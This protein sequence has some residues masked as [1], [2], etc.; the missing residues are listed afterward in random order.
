MS[1]H[2]V[3]PLRFQV[4]VISLVGVVAFLA[5][6]GFAALNEKL[7]GE[8]RATMDRTRAAN[9]LVTR[10]GL[11]FETAR[12]L[13]QR[14]IS[15]QRSALA[16]AEGKAMGQALTL[17][18]AA[19]QAGGDARLGKEIAELRRLVDVYR[20]DFATVQESLALLGTT[21]TP[22]LQAALD[23]AAM[24]LEE[25]L[26]VLALMSQT[27]S[28]AVVRLQL[29]VARQRGHERDFRRSGDTVHSA[30]MVAPAAAFDEALEEAGL[31]AAE[32]GALEAA[33]AAYRR[34]FRGYSDVRV[35]MLNQIEQQR[36]QAARLG[37][38]MEELLTHN[39]ARVAAQAVETE[40]R[41]AWLEQANL[42]G[43]VVALLAMAGTGIAIGRLIARRVARMVDAVEALA[44][45]RR[46]IA[47]PEA[48]LVRDEMTELAEATRV[49]RE[50]LI[51][52][53]R[54]A[55]A[56]A[57]AQVQRQARQDAM[58]HHTARFA[59]SIAGILARLGAASRGI[60][61]AARQMHTQAARSGEAVGVT[62]ADAQRVGGDLAA[63]AAA[64]E[65]LGASVNEITRQVGHA[66]AQIGAATASVGATE[67]E[68]GGL[69]SRA[70]EIE[71][72]LGS[73]AEIAA[74]TSLL[75][76]NA[77][78]EAARAGE[79]GRGFAVVAGEVKALAERSSRSAREIGQRID[80]VRHASS[81]AEAEMAR[82]V[83][84]IRGVEGVAAMIAAAVEEQE[85]ATR[86]IAST[87]QLVNRANAAT[88]ATLTEVA[89]IAQQ[90]GL[91]SQVVLGTAE[92]LAAVAETLDAEVGQFLA[93]MRG[94]EA[95]APV[96]AEQRMAL[97]A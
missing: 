28:P 17:L 60:D 1:R 25:R 64:A 71:T 94:D 89:G 18:A 5:L 65:Q 46:D 19:E 6:A 38:A 50:A 20:R 70:R 27:P 43:L 44:Q 54:M 61:G 92:E 49:F 87:I 79:A 55:V 21:E 39:E 8:A 11:H 47:L 29:A 96:V 30:G 57:A 80:G 62:A 77:T 35:E 31:P 10:A 13:G 93:D 68:V 22:G 73:I 72:I 88:N 16:Q 40:E 42:V 37:D 3:I 58:E 78:I 81:T 4:L 59:E 97:A 67:R 32:S 86:E 23:A 52:N 90:T 63:V 15:E 82:L 83:E 51:E 12:E 48:G 7:I 41:T 45:G 76:L 9:L 95:A 36:G 74:R 69:A 34:A 2:Y 91:Q 84:A 53:E 85:S 75:S 14:F 66:S 24:A 33:Q 56:A 26:E